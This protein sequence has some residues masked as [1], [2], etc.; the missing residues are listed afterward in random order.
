MSLCRS[1]SRAMLAP[2][3]CLP[4]AAVPNANARTMLRPTSISSP[5]GSL[6]AN[7]LSHIIDGSSLSTPYVSGATNFDAYVATTLHNGDSSFLGVGFTDLPGLPQIITFDL[8]LTAT[9]NGMAYWGMEEPGGTTQFSLFA[10]NDDDYLNGT[11]SP[12]GGLNVVPLHAQP[13]LADVINFSATTA[14]YV[15]FQ[16]I[17]GVG[18]P[19]IY[20]G[21]GEVA[22][23]IVPE[24]S[25]LVIAGATAGLMLLFRSRGRF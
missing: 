12:L 9:I 8:G 19:D 20:P 18:G 13:Q 17:A 24:P 5:W 16:A 1:L 15:H 22:F 3:V 7:P 14:R 23:A 10:D 25:G 2:L 6:E 4:L 21:L 11:S